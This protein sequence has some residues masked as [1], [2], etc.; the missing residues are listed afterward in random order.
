MEQ[1]LC[2]VNDF[3]Q[4]VSI[5]GVQIMNYLNCRPLPP[6]PDL[7]V[8]EESV[9]KAADVL[10][11]WINY[12]LLIARDIAIDGNLKLF[13][14]VCSSCFSYSPLPFY[15][16]YLC[17]KWCDVGVDFVRLLPVCGWFLTLEVSSTF[18]LCYIL[19]STY[20]FYPILIRY[21]PAFFIPVIHLPFTQELF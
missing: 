14:Q 8:S 16:K 21:F 4:K 12:I 13:V 15:L 3:V 7:E 2:L 6:L 17:C 18:L 19:V 10:R 1:L 20:S 5:N 9:I 11:V